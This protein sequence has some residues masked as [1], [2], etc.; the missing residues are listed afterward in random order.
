MGYGGAVSFTGPVTTL[1]ITEFCWRLSTGRF[2]LRNTRFAWQIRVVF[3]QSE[4]CV[5]FCF[6]LKRLMNT[7]V[8]GPG[9]A[10]LKNRDQCPGC[11]C[12]KPEKFFSYPPVVSLVV[13]LQRMLT[14]TKRILDLSAVTYLHRFFSR[15]KIVN[16]TDSEDQ[17][18]GLEWHAKH[19]I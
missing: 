12:Y 8:C 3:L 11:A 9:V 6:F 13:R 7:I 10:C 19:F 14:D 5:C 1:R 16:K 17:A 2:R 15:Q 4:N 18:N